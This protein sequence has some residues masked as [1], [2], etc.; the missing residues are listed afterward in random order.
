MP[1]EKNDQTQD[2]AQVEAGEP[3]A[4]PQ[5]DKAADKPKDEKKYTDAEVNEIINQRFARWEREHEAKLQAEKDKLTEAQKLEKMNEAEKAAYTTEKLQARIE[6]LEREK[7]LAEQMAVARNALKD[8]NI[9]ISD[10][11]LAM[12]VSPDAETTKRA[13]DSFKEM[14]TK[15]V[16]AAV[17]DALKRTPPKSEPT[18]QG[19]GKSYG[20]S[21]A[22]RVNQQRV[23]VKSE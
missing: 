7:S 19:K 11:L 13:V 14:W 6:E 20:A 2:V 1:E 21:F 8:D 12:I 23:P 5:A 15:D 16:N 10:D 22:E 18:T 17:Q 3:Q 9:V 4:E